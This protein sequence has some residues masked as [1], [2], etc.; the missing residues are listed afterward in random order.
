LLE[1][2]DNIIRRLDCWIEHNGF[3]GWD[4]YDLGQ[5][6]LLSRFREDKPK[7]HHKFI[8]RMI[9]GLGGIFPFF[10]RKLFGVKS[11]VNAK[12][13][14]LLLAGYS[15][16]YIATNDQHYL[17]QAKKY[18]KWLMCNGG[19]KYS[20]H[21]WGYPFDWRSVTFI[22][23]GTPSS[24]VTS[25]V[26]DG[27]YLLYK[28]TNETRYLEICKEICC[29]FVNDL[30][31]TVNHPEQICFSYTPIDDFQVHNA[32]LFVGEFLV[33]IGKETGEQKWY[34]TGLKCGNFALAEQHNDGYL[35]Y[36]SLAQTDSHNG[37]KIHTD[38]YH[39]GFE[40]RMLYRLWK[41]TGMEKFK[42]AYLKYYSWYQSRMFT[43]DGR[44]KNGPESYYPVNIHSIAEG[45][46]CKAVLFEDHPDEFQQLKHIIYWGEKNMEYADGEYVYMIKKNPIIGEWHL[47][48]PMLRWGQAWMFRALS[49]AKIALSENID[50]SGD[51]KEELAVCQSKG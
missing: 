18:A 31:K 12:A 10:T 51:A 20:G 3:A 22:P 15:N 29:F 42:A 13:M 49:Q 21:N 6:K 30:K 9:F 1:D 16:M 32:N 37:G 43:S 46:L 28:A 7:I 27:F 47:R 11:Q 35:P 50:S 24:V 34:E 40:I 5:A 4:P 41:L 23:H 17:D 33:R 48:I 14:G 2:L 25:I 44:V 45:I 38:H 36:W 19:R 39:S 8:R 26:G